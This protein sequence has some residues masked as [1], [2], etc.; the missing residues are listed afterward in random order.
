MN[1]KFLI[2][3]LLRVGGFLLLLAT[4]AI[5]LPVDVMAGIHR[6]LGVGE[7]PDGPITAYLARSTSA[8][9]AMHGAMMLMVSIDVVKYFRFVVLLGWLHTVFG[10]VIFFTGLLAPLPWYWVLG[11]GPPVVAIGLL[12]VFL[13]RKPIDRRS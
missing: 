3:F 10:I 11:E 2:T 4:F 7:Y 5:F 6:W 1:R 8:L 12:L 13:S 9:Y